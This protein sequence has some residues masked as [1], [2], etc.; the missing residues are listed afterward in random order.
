[1]PKNKALVSLVAGLGLILMAGLGV[2]VWGLQKQADDPTFKF[3]KKTRVPNTAASASESAKNPTLNFSIPLPPSYRI[4]SV[5][6]E[7]S[8]LF[9][10]ITNELNQDRVLVLDAATGAV[11]RRFKF[12][13]KP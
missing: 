11:I 1:M 4:L 7:G 5:D 10:H 2:L 12:H 8:R 9:L 3:F 6:A 13:T